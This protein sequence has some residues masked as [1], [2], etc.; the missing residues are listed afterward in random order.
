M[1]NL[2]TRP[3]IA[4]ALVAFDAALESDCLIKCLDQCLASYLVPPLDDLA[5]VFATPKLEMDDVDS[6]PDG[7]IL[8][9]DFSNFAPTAT[10]FFCDCR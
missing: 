10:L 7:L 8:P 4:T 2:R 9:V 1:R 5:N 3:G 6:E